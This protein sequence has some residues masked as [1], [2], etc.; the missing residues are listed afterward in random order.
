MVRGITRIPK[1][2]GWVL[3][4]TVIPFIAGVISSALNLTFVA[5][6]KGQT[7]RLEPLSTSERG[8]WK[9]LNCTVTNRGW[10]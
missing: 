8:M 4:K 2:S 6:R 10:L 7:L 9:F 1:E 3:L 5:V